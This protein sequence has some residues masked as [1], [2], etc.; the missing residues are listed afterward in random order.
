MAYRKIEECLEKLAELYNKNEHGFIKAYLLMPASVVSFLDNLN[1]HN[2]KELDLIEFYKEIKFYYRAY[3]ES[4]PKS[5]I[6][7][8]FTL[9]SPEDLV[10][11]EIHL[12]K[13]FKLREL[14]PYY[15]IKYLPLS[16]LAYWDK[17]EDL[18]ETSLKL[19]RDSEAY[20][21]CLRKS[22]DLAYSFNRIHNELFYNISK[23]VHID[24]DDYYK[25][26]EDE[27]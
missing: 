27:E 7:K 21:R 5:R 18:K 19:E 10:N 8:V 12:D 11:F 17:L 16:P 25:N 20:L 15:F 1:P 14:S 13:M 22:K 3:L 2:E 26:T 9:R 24:D 4:L 23:D 6:V